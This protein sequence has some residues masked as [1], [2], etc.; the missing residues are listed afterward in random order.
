MTNP[1]LSTRNKEC[2]RATKQGTF[3]LGCVLSHDTLFLSLNEHIHH[4]LWH[5]KTEQDK[6]ATSLVSRKLHWYWTLLVE[7]FLMLQ[8]C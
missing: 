7:M 2:V 5:G 4:L 8:K 1:L 6:I 3:L